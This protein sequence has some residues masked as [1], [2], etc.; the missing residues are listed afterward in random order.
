[1]PLELRRPGVDAVLVGD[2]VPTSPAPL[3]GPPH[4]S[5]RLELTQHTQ[6]LIAPTF[7]KLGERGTRDPIVLGQQPFER[8]CAHELTRPAPPRPSPSPDDRRL[9][10]GCLRR[11][12][13]AALQLFT[14]GLQKINLS[15]QH[16]KPV[17]NGFR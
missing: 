13:A 5:R 10:H 14:S 4:A 15:T 11:A 2:R 7:G 6:H 1:L 12:R 8:A 17:L 16:V 9:P 3:P